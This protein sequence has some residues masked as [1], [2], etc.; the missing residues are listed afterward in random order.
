MVRVIARYFLVCMISPLYFHLH[1]LSPSHSSW[2]TMVTPPEEHGLEMTHGRVIRNLG[3]MI[4]AMVFFACC[5]LS[6]YLRLM[7]RLSRTYAMMIRPTQADFA[8]RVH[9]T[10]H[11]IVVPVGLLWS[12]H[13]CELWGQPLVNTCSSAE[14]FFSISVGY[15][16]VDLVIISFFKIEFWPVFVTHHIFALLPYAINNFVPHASHCH[17]LLSMALTSK[18]LP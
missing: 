16:L 18:P 8:S 6:C 15:F 12:I 4:L 1:V 11:A 7:P 5:F 17:Y 13:H 2:V 3:A 10:I 9:S 14:V